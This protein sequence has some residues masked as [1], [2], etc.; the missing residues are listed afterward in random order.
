M[1]T[2]ILKLVETKKY[3]LNRLGTLHAGQCFQLGKQVG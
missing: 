2:A 1:E 3:L